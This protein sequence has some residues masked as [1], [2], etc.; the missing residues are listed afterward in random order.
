MADSAYPADRTIPPCP[1]TGAPARRCI[2][3][4]DAAFLTLLWR[5]SGRVDVGKLLL[6]AGTFRLWESPTGLIF[7]DPPVA[8]DAAFYRVFYGQ[9]AAH[10]KLAGPAT[11]RLEFRRAAAHVADGARVLDV[12][13]G[14]GGFRAYVPNAAYTGL[15]PNFSAEDP[16]GAILD[17]TVEAHAARLGPVY[18]VACAFQVIEHVADPLGF[19]RALAACV[20][21][22]GLVLIGTPLWPSPNTTIPNFVIN[23]PPH[24]LTWWTPAAL[25]ALAGTLGCT[26]EAVHAIGMDRHDSLIHWM[27]KV[28]PVRCRDRFFRQTWRW[29]LALAVAYRIG[30]FLDRWLPVPKRTR[31]NALLLVARKGA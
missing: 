1:I 27:A 17:E 12:G 8:G 6:P 13:C 11:E 3:R 19:A 7:F 29:V 14:H 24:H 28:T 21:P 23:A 25:E 5:F 4:L 2:E 18:D 30:A 10:D 9:I 20:R 15:D 22:G 26:P 31:P 16:T